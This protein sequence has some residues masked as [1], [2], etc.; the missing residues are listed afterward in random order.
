MVGVHGRW[1]C[2]AHESWEAKKTDNQVSV[3][4]PFQEHVLS[5]TTPSSWAPLPQDALIFQLFHAEDWAINTRDQGAF[6][7]QMCHSTWSQSKEDKEGVIPLFLLFFFSRQELTV[8][9]TLAW[10]SPFLPTQPPRYW[11]PLPHLA[12]LY[13]IITFTSTASIIEVSRDQE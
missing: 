3:S 7:I 5:D 6:Q 11:D 9:P 1:R 13:R 4:S 10:K 2:L 12:L 8:Y